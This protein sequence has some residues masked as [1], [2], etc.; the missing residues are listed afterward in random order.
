VHPYCLLSIIGQRREIFSP[1][2]PLA[3]LGAPVSHNPYPNGITVNKK[4]V[5]QFACHNNYIKATGYF[6]IIG[7]SQALSTLKLLLTS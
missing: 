4:P 2:Y 5:K 7:L 6:S 3:G 1:G